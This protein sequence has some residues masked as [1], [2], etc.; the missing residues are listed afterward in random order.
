[1]KAQI[2]CWKQASSGIRLVFEPLPECRADYHC[3]QPE[4]SE[5]LFLSVRNVSALND[6]ELRI[7]AI[8][9]EKDYGHSSKSDE[10]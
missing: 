6:A 5:D 4:A 7:C 8:G 2:V 1:M 10:D 9:E 3:C